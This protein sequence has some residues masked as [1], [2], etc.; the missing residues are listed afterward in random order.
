MN[1]QQRRT[2]VNG[3]QRRTGV[4][5]QQR[6]TGV[7]EQKVDDSLCFFTGLSWIRPEMAMIDRSRV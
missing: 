7:N 2:G 5:G 4:N 6:R 1:G 3:Q